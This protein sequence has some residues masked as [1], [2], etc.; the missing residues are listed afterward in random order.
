MAIELHY[1]PSPKLIGYWR[2][3]I[4]LNA[5]VTTKGESDD[6]VLVLMRNYATYSMNYLL[7]TRNYYNLVKIFMYFKCF[8]VN[9]QERQHKISNNNEA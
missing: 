6:S 3:V 4:V 1:R 7:D 9:V 2:Y 8:K 5:H